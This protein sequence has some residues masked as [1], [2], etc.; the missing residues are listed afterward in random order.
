MRLAPPKGDGQEQ[1]GASIEVDLQPAAFSTSCCGVLEQKT[2]GD[3]LHGMQ[4]ASRGHKRWCV[5]ADGWLRAYTRQSDAKPKVVVQVSRAVVTAQPFKGGK[6]WEMLISIQD[7]TPGTSPSHVVL[8][9]SKQQTK[10]W[11][12]KLKAASSQGTSGT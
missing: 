12:S 11:V 8:L 3:L 4:P 2:P 5:L 7:S 6:P 10:E 1:E 9:P